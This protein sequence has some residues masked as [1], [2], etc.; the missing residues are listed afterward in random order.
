MLP[1]IQ[2][3]VLLRDPV[4]RAFSHYN[5]MHSRGAESLSFEEAIEREQER[6][7]AGE[8]EWE[9]AHQAF[10]YI[11]RG[12]YAPQLREWFQHFDRSRILI[13]KSEDLY[14]TANETLDR[15]AHFLSLA[16]ADWRIKQ[17]L[18]PGHYRS[19]LNP[20]V[21]QRLRDFYS[22][23]NIELRNL[24]GPDFDWGY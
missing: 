22:P 14:S 11:S 13:L 3:I 20:A 2:L 4:K 10:S 24:I 6:L 18:N 16:L 1:E 15:T 21:A 9:A 7:G 5:H 8:P 17:V 12:I 19:T 23:H